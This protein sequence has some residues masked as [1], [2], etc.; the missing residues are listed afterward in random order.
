MSHLQ[1]LLSTVGVLLLATAVLRIRAVEECT[2][3]KVC[4]RTQCCSIKLKLLVCLV[5]PV[6]SACITF[7]T[8]LAPSVLRIMCINIPFM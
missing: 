4:L 5:C 7:I 2:V 8:S 3:N 1:N 6:I